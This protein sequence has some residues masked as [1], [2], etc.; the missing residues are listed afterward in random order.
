MYQIL[1]TDD[2]DYKIPISLTSNTKIEGTYIDA[3]TAKATPTTPTTRAVDI[4]GL[5]GTNVSAAAAVVNTSGLAVA[6]PN[7]RTEIVNTS[8]FSELTVEK[9]SMDINDIKNYFNTNEY[10]VT[11]TTDSKFE[12]ILKSYIS[13]PV[14]SPVTE[15]YG[16]NS[17]VPVNAVSDSEVIGKKILLNGTDIYAMILRND[18]VKEYILYLDTEYPIKYIDFLDGSTIFKYKAAPDYKIMDGKIL[19]YNGLVDE[20][21]ILS[22]VFIDRGVNNVFEP[23]KRLKNID[24]LKELMKVGLGYYKIN[25][26]GFNFKNAK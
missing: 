20:P 12:T 25:S 13:L 10:F 21:K 17:I 16:F 4:F 1:I 5:V 15:T 18:T 14:L 6:R 11:G 3:E 9:R 19:Y 26:T 24:N 22:E 7:I 23:V 2:E 8:Q